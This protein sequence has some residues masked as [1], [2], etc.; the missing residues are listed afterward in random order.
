MQAPAPPLPVT[1]SQLAR[2]I[3]SFAELEL[4][5]QRAS[6]STA[7]LGSI[8]DRIIALIEGIAPTSVRGSRF[9]DT[10]DEGDADF[11]R[12]AEAQ[13]EAAFRRFQV[14][15]VAERDLPEVSNLDTSMLRAR[16]RI[17][18]A[19]PQDNR[20]GSKAGRDRD[21]LIDEDF[22]KCDYLVG[23]YGRANFSGTYDATP[24]GCRTPNVIHGD[25]V[26]FLEI[27]ASYLYNLDVDA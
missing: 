23:I 1:W 11:Q 8:R 10:R 17:L 2:P 4:E 21:V 6:V 12:W 19:Y 25:G 20:A 9:K 22:R 16:F 13:K 7:T 26:D 5:L 14:R 15:A 18:I 3:E 27:E 24:L